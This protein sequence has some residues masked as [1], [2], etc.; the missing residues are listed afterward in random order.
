M[1]N[2]VLGGVSSEPI[3]ILRDIRI[4]IAQNIIL[5]SVLRLGY[6]VGIVELHYAKQAMPKFITEYQNGMMLVRYVTR[7]L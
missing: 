1:L 2:E 6:T 7:N 5:E 4:A 3:S